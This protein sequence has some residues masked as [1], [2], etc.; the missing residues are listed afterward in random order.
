MNKDTTSR[1]FGG[2]GEGIGYDTPDQI[3]Q[4]LLQRPHLIDKYV[5]KQLSLA[6][7]M[8]GWGDLIG[9]RSEFNFLVDVLE[10]LSAGG[11]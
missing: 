3:A 2:G 8:W 9:I 11:I 1:F 4:W 6:I 7:G 10:L 5:E